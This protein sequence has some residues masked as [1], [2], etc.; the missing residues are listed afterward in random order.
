MPQYLS[1]LESRSRVG[2]TDAEGSEGPSCLLW[3]YLFAAQHADYH[4][5]DT[6]RALELIDKAIA[7]TPTVG[8][9]VVCDVVLC[10]SY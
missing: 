8:R 1:E 7:H 9:W 4:H 5:H 6:T 10:P 2:A 3:A